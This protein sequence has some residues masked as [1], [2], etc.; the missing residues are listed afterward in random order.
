MVSF[1]DFMGL[2]GNFTGLNGENHRKIR[3]KWW[4]YGILWD[5]MGIFMGLNGESHRKTIGKWWFFM[6]FDGGLMVVWDDT[7]W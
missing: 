6:G 4:F 7:H 3:G 5:L 1:W 2:Y